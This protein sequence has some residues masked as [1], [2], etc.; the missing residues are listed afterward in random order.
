MEL[1][2]KCPVWIDSSVNMEIAVKRIL[3]GKMANLGQ[4]CV[5]PDYLICTEDVKDRFI[6]TAKR[7]Y[8]DFFGSE[9]EKS[10]DL[11]RIVNS[12]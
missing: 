7:V 10:S 1:G 8:V 5:A 3:W 11:C 12:R 2:G 4:T 6:A 9:A